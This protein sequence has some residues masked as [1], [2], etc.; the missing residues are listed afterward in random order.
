[1]P[2]FPPIYADLSAPNIAYWLPPR[3][4]TERSPRWDGKTIWLSHQPI[5]WYDNYIWHEDRFRRVDGGSIV[6]GVADGT[7]NSKIYEPI[8]LTVAGTNA[9]DKTNYRSK[10]SPRLSDYS[11]TGIVE[12]YLNGKKLITNV[13]F[14]QL[15][16]SRSTV[17]VQYTHL[18]DGV[19][20]EAK[21]M[22]QSNGNSPIIDDYTIHLYPQVHPHQD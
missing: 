3:E 12:F 8:V 20:V 2:Q 5:V 21:M 11:N 15:N 19:R 7:V 4:I 17:S 1:M 10:E 13:Y 18:T 22:A 6:L 14:E 16:V 9:L